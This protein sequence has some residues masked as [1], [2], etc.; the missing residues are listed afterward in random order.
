MPTQRANAS[1]VHRY[2]IDSTSLYGFWLIL[3]CICMSVCPISTYASV[4]RSSPSVSRMLSAQTH[5]SNATF[6]DLPSVS[7]MGTGDQCTAETAGAL[8]YERMLVRFRH[9][10]EV[11]THK[12]AVLG[13]LSSAF[14]ERGSLW[15]WLDRKNAAMKFPTDFGVLWVSR[16]HKSVLLSFLSGLGCVKDVLPDA[17]VNHTPQSL[18]GEVRAGSPFLGHRK[19]LPAWEEHDLL[20]NGTMYK[21]LDEDLEDTLGN[22]RLS[23]VVTI[24][25]MYHARKAWAMGYTGKGI[26]IG[27]FDTGLRQDNPSIRNIVDSSDWTWQGTVEDGLGHGSFVAG[28]MASTNKQCPGT[29]PD[30]D[31]YTFKVFTD[32]QESYTSWY[33]DALNYAMTLDLDIINVSIGGP[34]YTDRPFIDKFREIVARGVTMF[35]ANGNDGLWGA[36]NN[37]A[38]EHFVFGV[39]GVTSK[40]TTAGFQSR[41]MTIQE[42]PYGYGRPKPD[43]ASLGALVY[44][45]HIHGDCKMMSGT[46]FASPVM[47]GLAAVVA[48]AIPASSRDKR[49]NPSAL[50]QI[51]LE[52]A[53][54]ISGI[55]LYQ[56]G[57]GHV[58]LL[59]S[60]SIARNYK[61]KVT[62]FPSALDLTDEHYMWP[63]AQM[64]LYATSMPLRL[65]VTILNAFSATG[66][67]AEGPTWQP[68]NALGESLRFRFDY[69]EIIWPWAGWLG[70]TVYVDDSISSSVLSG[71]SQVAEGTIVFKVLSDPH[72]GELGHSLFEVKLP[73][74]ARVVATPPRA[75][76]ILWDDYHNIQYPPLYVPIDDKSAGGD[77]FDWNGDHPHSNFRG[78]YNELIEQGYFIEVLSSSL[79]CF[80]ASNYG[81]LILADTEGEFHREEIDK[82]YLD[83]TSGGLGLIILGEWHN[84]KRMQSLSHYDENARGFW[85]PIVGG[86]NVPALNRLL[87]KFGVAYSDKVSGLN[88]YSVLNI[89]GDN[90]NIAEGSSIGKLPAGS[91]G[92]YDTENIMVLG[93]VQAEQGHIAVFVDTGC[94]DDNTK[95]PR[96]Q[97]FITKLVRYATKEMQEGWVASGIKMESAYEATDGRIPNMHEKMSAFDLEV[98]LRPLQCHANS[99]LKYAPPI[100][101]HANNGTLLEHY[102]DIVNTT[103]EVASIS[104][105]N[106][107]YVSH[108]FDKHLSMEKLNMQ[109]HLQ[110]QVSSAFLIFA[111]LILFVWKNNK[112]KYRLQRRDN[113]LRKSIESV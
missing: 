28:S 9:F 88:R 106:T 69:S 65:N 4:L 84:E 94:M 60:V 66:Y 68:S 74:K 113:R 17:R 99:P 39:G 89:A 82:L 64:P 109:L 56:S 31:I 16:A 79:T 85:R 43:L 30:V 51:L 18:A 26:K 35:S 5:M 34:D 107:G 53:D 96:C 80:D 19:Y 12:E 55:S 3:W 63:H 22:R 73:F 61:P 70:L 100:G 103:L 32:A 67:V 75:K 90:I 36:S 108:Y 105:L 71:G 50:R 47:V 14:G 111:C 54:R 104:T 21:D 33:L 27:I 78:L 98:L 6:D 29:A 59:R 81:A 23:G 44:S 86:A 7:L 110:W 2:A 8:V 97:G 11:G 48:S 13:A 95:S 42:A 92:F 10:D 1:V 38:D 72:P 112:G 25:E 76:R 15:Q 45:S 93:L 62:C 87:F 102:S 52:G 49:V 83:V 77:H 101:D 58:N 40:A 57:A 41:G 24:S 91:I 46:S 37:P 20:P